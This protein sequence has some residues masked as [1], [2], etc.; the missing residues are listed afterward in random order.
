MKRSPA[1]SVYTCTVNAIPGREKNILLDGRMEIEEVIG[2]IKSLKEKKTPGSD[3]IPGK[4]LKLFN[5]NNSCIS[6]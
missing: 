4:V 3:R 5:F 1:A 6:L 2:T